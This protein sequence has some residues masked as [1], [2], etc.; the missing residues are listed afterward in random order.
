MTGTIPIRVVRDQPHDRLR[1]PLHDLRISLIDR[2]NFRCPY[3]MPAEDYPRHHAFLRRSQRMLPGEIVRLARLFVRLGVRKLRLTGGEPLLLRELPEVIRGLAG[4][5]GVEDLAMTSNGSLL[6]ARA[7]GLRQA[8]LQRLTVSLDS[9]QAERFRQLSGGLGD[10]DD[11][12]AGIAAADAAGLAPIKINAVIQ[13][14][15][16]DDEV[17]ALAEHFRGT[18][19]TLRF[20]EFM[21]VGTCNGWQADKVV[22]SAQLLAR[23]HARWPLE[24]VGPAHA[25]EVARRYRYLDGAGEVG[26]ISSVSQPF[27]GA[28]SRARLS[29][30]GRLYTCLF[31]GH[32]H[33]LLTPMREGEDDAALLARI[34]AIWSARQDRYSQLRSQA[35]A[36]DGPSPDRVE[37]YSIGG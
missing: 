13:R 25:G 14:D 32:G 2:C 19:H 27:C 29:A 4:I 1:R 5:A 34:C 16:N 17:E 22:A 12:L 3:C 15:V 20:I 9:L 35:A 23:I 6:A 28:C 10:L 8:G 30:D 7:A 31:T 24:A 33:D 21:D 26:F 36:G 18:G 37:M 11:T